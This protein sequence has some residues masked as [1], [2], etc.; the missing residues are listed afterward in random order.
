MK[1]EWNPL[2]VKPVATMTFS[3][4]ARPLDPDFTKGQPVIINGSPYRVTG[5]TDD[6]DSVT[7]DLEPTWLDDHRA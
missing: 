3:G 2:D 6:G 4:D 7:Y 1:L 5:V